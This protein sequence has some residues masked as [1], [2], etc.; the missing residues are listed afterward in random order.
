[1][2]FWVHLQL[3]VFTSLLTESLPGLLLSVSSP[4]PVNSLELHLAVD[5]GER[6]EVLLAVLAVEEEDA[7]H[8]GGPEFHG[9]ADRVVSLHGVKGQVG[10][11]PERRNEVLDH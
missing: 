4:P 6:Q 11:T 3:T 5:Q 1:M 8:L 10:L 9:D 7:R 2:S